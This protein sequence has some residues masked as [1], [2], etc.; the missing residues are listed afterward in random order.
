MA[1]RYSFVAPLEALLDALPRVIARPIGAVIVFLYFRWKAL[2]ALTVPSVVAGA[3]A[4][5]IAQQLSPQE[6]ALTLLAL[7]WLVALAW[8][9]WCDAD[10][11][12]KRVHELETELE[13]IAEYE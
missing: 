9:Q 11:L 2:I 6:A 4:P 8:W 3:L 12:R 10:L 13:G 5:A 7:C 1:S